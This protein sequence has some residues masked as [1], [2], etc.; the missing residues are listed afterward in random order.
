MPAATDPDQGA[1]RAQAYELYGLLP[2]DFTGARNAAAATLRSEG[3][4]EQS[5]R[6][7]ALRKPGTAAWA[8][9]TMVRRM[10]ERLGQL[11]DLGAELREAQEDLD[12]AQLRALSTGRRRLVG[13]VVQ[14][15]RSLCRSLGQPVS[16]A[17]ATQ[18]EATLQAAMA[19]PD[20]E[21]AVLSGL[22]VE[23]LQVIGMGPVD[24]T[25]AVAIE[26]AVGSRPGTKHRSAPLAAVVEPAETP[27]QAAARLLAEAREEAAEADRQQ[28]RATEVQARASK[29]ADT[30]QAQSLR[31]RSQVEELRRQAF[32]LEHELDQVERALATAESD[33]AEA[34]AARERADSGAER[35]RAE[36]V[37]L[38]GKRRR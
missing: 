23:P 6:V 36:V 19:D 18:V 32:E 27:D 29:R 26:G 3:D 12:G 34:E 11:F 35:A 38:E 25:G 20:A 7:K 1:L 17:V 8:V 5:K 14:E 28:R 37:R 21:G 13:A 24:L 2:G 31:V 9:N 16:E 15:G 22:L 30:L 4:P 10:D 33:R